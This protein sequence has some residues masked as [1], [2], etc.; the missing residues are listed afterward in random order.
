MID[1]YTDIM[2]EEFRSYVPKLVMHVMIN[3]LRRFLATNI[4]TRMRNYDAETLFAT[5][6]AE[7]LRL[8]ELT[9]SHQ[10][11]QNAIDSI[12]EVLAKFK[13]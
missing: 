5:D 2:R 1:S 9:A 10:S 13:Y 4:H 6:P 8:K 7:Q 12:D 11:C 3:R